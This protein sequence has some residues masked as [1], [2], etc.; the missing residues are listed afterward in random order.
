MVSVTGSTSSGM[1]SVDDIRTEFET[2]LLRGD[3]GV[4]DSPNEELL[5]TRRD[6]TLESTELRLDDLPWLN[7]LSGDSTVVLVGATTALADCPRPSDCGRGS[8]GDC[9]E[10]APRGTD[11]DE[12]CWLSFEGDDGRCG[13]D[14]VPDPAMRGDA[15]RGAEDTVELG[16][17]GGKLG[18]P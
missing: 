6:A 10:S 4:V 11:V 5:D 7:D 18:E 17:G 14:S 8:G 16:L 15:M 1:S 9:I 2:R 12:D 3:V 13:G